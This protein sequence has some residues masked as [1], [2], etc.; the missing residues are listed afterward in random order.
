MLRC[1]LRVKTSDGHQANVAAGVSQLATFHVGSDPLLQ[2]GERERS[3][4][5]GAVAGEYARRLK[6]V[7]VERAELLQS[8][9]M[10]PRNARRFESILDGV[11]RIERFDIEV[12]VMR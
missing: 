9:R 12:G 3:D 1:R 6:H 7:D 2:S 4:R 5:I 8:V 10:E 11:N